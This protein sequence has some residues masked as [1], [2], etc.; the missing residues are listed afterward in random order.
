M[1]LNV[2]NEAGSL[3]GRAGWTLTWDVFKCWKGN[4]TFSR[5]SSWTLTWDV[6][7]LTQGA[8]KYANTRV[9]L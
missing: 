9:E 7:K 6:F 2:Q 8:K 1:Y 4:A 3:A 5:T